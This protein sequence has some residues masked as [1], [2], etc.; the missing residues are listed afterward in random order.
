VHIDPFETAIAA[1]YR[2]MTW[3]PLPVF[4]PY[5]TFTTALDEANADFLRSERAPERILR[6]T[7]AGVPTTIDGR[8]Y[9]FDSPAAKLAMLCRYAPLRS[10]PV[11]QILARS[12]DRCGPVDWF[13]EIRTTIGA[14]V[15]VPWRERP[16]TIVVASVEGVAATVLDRAEGLLMKNQPWWISFAPEVRYR[17]VLGT[18]DSTLLMGVPDSLAWPADFG[19][20]GYAGAFTIEDDSGERRDPIVVRFGSIPIA[21]P[22]PPD[23]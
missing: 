11:W 13:A 6:W 4:Q 23:S 7:P 22:M 18:A 21:S 3:R 15:P 17:L 8:A 20:A 9:Y 1:G 2:S 16:G 12:G 14:S 19:L 5:S 10:E